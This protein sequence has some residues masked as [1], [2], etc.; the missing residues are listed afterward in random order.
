MA[1]KPEV[2]PMTSQIDAD[3][4]RAEERNW[5]TEVKTSL[6][7]EVHVGIVVPAAETKGEP[8]GV[9]AEAPRDRL[10]YLAQGVPGCMASGDTNSTGNTNH[11][12]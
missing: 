11:D 8:L 6:T 9:Q 1:L 5:G 2:K 10:A 3:E 7:E 4:S 12:W